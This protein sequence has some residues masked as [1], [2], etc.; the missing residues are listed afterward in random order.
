MSNPV[1]R[2]EPWLVATVLAIL[3]IAALIEFG[4]KNQ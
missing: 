4:V 1:F 2:N 3:W